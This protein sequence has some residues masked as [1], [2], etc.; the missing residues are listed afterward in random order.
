MNF[1]VK[2]SSWLSGQ[3][4]CLL[5]LQTRFDI[6]V[7]THDGF[8]RPGRACCFSPSTQDT[9]VSLDAPTSFIQGHKKA[10]PFLRFC[11]KSSLI[12]YWKK[13]L[14]KK[15]CKTFCDILKC[16]AYVSQVILSMNWCFFTTKAYVF[17]RILQ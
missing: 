12:K 1:Y 16:K 3:C 4:S 6:G 17:F 15:Q 10:I 7:S 9:L 8:R 14:N 13:K 2:L 5:T 11:K